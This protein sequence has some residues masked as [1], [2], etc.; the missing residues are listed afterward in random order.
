MASLANL[1]AKIDNVDHKIVKLLAER[2]RYVHAI[3]ELKNSEEEIVAAERQEQVL[4][5]RRAWARQHGA[6]P[7]LV[8]LLYRQMIDFFIEQERL[9]LAARKKNTPPE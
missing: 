4:K 6:D 2:A 8:E 7:E 3:G 5:T 1:R 9:Q